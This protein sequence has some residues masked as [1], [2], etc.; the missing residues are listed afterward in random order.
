MTNGAIIIIIESYRRNPN[1]A[2]VAGDYL[3]KEAEM[4][5]TDASLINDNP[6]CVGCRY[7]T[8]RSRGGMGKECN[9]GTM[10]DHRRC[11]EW[12]INEFLETHTF[13][14]GEVFSVS[15]VSQWL[16]GEIP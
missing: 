8:F 6:R 12:A 1:P 11:P 10:D 7:N 4:R 5:V 16:R 14:K 2:R 9:G 3:R 13:K 15:M